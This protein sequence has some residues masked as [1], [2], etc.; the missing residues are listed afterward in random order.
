M[1]QAGHVACMGKRRAYK[2]LMGKPGGKRSLGRPSH[3][4]WGIILK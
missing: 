3:R 4:W 2:V 1:R